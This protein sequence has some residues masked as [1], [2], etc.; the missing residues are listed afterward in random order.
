MHGIVNDSGYYVGS[1]SWTKS[2][3]RLAEQSLQLT[4]TSSTGT[5][6]P[7]CSAVRTVDYVNYIDGMLDQVDYTFLD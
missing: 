7:P 2:I 6:R 4:T 3:D 5:C 1:A